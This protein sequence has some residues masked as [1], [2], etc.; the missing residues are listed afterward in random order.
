MKNNTFGILIPKNRIIQIR[1]KVNGIPRREM[2][3]GNIYK[4]A[5]SFL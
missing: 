1:R 5:V 4:N 3:F 2:K